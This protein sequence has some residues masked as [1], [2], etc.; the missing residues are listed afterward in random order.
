MSCKLQECKPCLCCGATAT[1]IEGY[2]V[3][4]SGC[5]E[6]SSLLKKVCN[7]CIL[8]LAGELVAREDYSPWADS[9]LGQKAAALKEALRLAQETAKAITGGN[10]Y[11]WHKKAAVEVPE[12][13]WQPETFYVVEVSYNPY[14]PSHKALLYTGFLDARGVPCGY[15]EFYSPNYEGPIEF[16]CGHY[17]RV[18]ANLGQ[19]LD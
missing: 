2:P 16:S 11:K 9:E 5:V 8:R 12:G 1:D 15:A 18:L 10:D 6:S 19:L 4:A 7:A 14:N 13:G 3:I 17:V